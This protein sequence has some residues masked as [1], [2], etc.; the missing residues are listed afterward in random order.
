MKF[1]NFFNRLID[2]DYFFWKDWLFFYV[3]NVL[4]L[5][6]KYFKGIFVCNGMV[7]ILDGKNFGFDK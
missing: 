6:K 5:N 3:K 4:S 2:L 1:Y 7:K